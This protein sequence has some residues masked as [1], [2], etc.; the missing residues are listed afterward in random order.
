MSN[1]GLTSETPL[2][3]DHL[4][5]TLQILNCIWEQNDSLDFR[6]PVDWKALQL[7]DY[8]SIVKRPIDLGTIKRNINNNKYKTVEH[9]LED[10]QLV[11]DNCKLY[12]QEGSVIF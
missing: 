11:W 9:V 3:R 5:N 12:N 4:K 7:L 2:E 6:V 1:L 8:L 10:I